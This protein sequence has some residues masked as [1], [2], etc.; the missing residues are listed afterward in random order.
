MDTKTTKALS[1]ISD[2]DKKVF[3]PLNYETEK[4]KIKWKQ[5]PEKRLAIEQLVDTDKYGLI[6]KPE[7]VRI[8]I[9]D[10]RYKKYLLSMKLNTLIIETKKGFHIYFRDV[11]GLTKKV[12]KSDFFLY[13][14]INAELFP[15]N[16]KHYAN[17]WLNH[18]DKKIFRHVDRLMELPM[19]WLPMKKSTREEHLIPIMQ[20]NR[21]TSLFN[22]LCILKDKFT[23]DAAFEIAN[24]IDIHANDTEPLGESIIWAKIKDVWEKYE[25]NVFDKS[26]FVDS[27]RLLHKDIVNHIIEN[28]NI[29]IIAEGDEKIVC[30]YTDDYYQLY[31]EDRVSGL[32]E[33]CLFGTYITAANINAIYKLL[34]K[35]TDI[36]LTWDKFNTH[37][38]K[39]FFKDCVYDLETNEVLAH[40]PNYINSFKMGVD[41][42]TLKYRDIKDTYFYKTLLVAYQWEDDELQMLYD[43]ISHIMVTSNHFKSLLFFEGESNTG[44]SLL[45]HSIERLFSSEL[46]AAVPLDQ[47]SDRFRA[48]DMFNKLLN[49]DGDGNADALKDISIIKKVTGSDLLSNE[50]KGRK[51]WNFRSFSKQIFAFNRLPKNTA[52]HSDAFYNRLRVLK[53]HHRLDLT[54]DTATKIKESIIETVPFLVDNLSKMYL[55]GITNSSRSQQYTKDL[56]NHSDSVAYFLSERVEKAKDSQVAKTDLYDSYALFCGFE[57]IIYPLNRQ[58]FNLEMEYRGLK[59]VR[60]SVGTRRVWHYVN[61]KVKEDDE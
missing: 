57:Q 40:S 38:Y 42:K 48:G 43:Y 14:Q 56:R 46:I 20:G 27:G 51:I 55:T 9:D 54:D 29:K 3:I 50:Q 2:L 34:I 52:E 13:N 10:K 33:D 32:I 25:T 37:K 58:K 21:D 5:Q 18:P 30:Y 8:D 7:I 41:F 19:D 45:Q 39:I 49:V 59:L 36:M 6:L 44:K 60:K 22:L 28:N 47:M 12:T 15:I 31:A 23:Q 61:I 4:P 24:R 1:L 16:S 53:F 11:G 26:L 17:I 35:Q